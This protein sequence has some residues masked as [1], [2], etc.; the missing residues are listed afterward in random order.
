MKQFFL[1]KHT[2]YAYSGSSW[3]IV[4]SEDVLGVNLNIKQKR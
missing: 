4:D 2:I 1:F 3:T